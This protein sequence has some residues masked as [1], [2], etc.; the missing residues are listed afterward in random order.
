MTNRLTWHLQ[1][2]VYPPVTL[3]MIPYC[4]QAIEACSEGRESEAIDI[5]GTRIPAEE[6]VEDLR[7]WEMVEDASLELIAQWEQE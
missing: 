1:Y 3:E 6:I 4:E 2:N 7:L 5:N